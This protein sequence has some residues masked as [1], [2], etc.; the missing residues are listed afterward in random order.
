MIDKSDL[1]TLIETEE[2]RGKRRML[3]SVSGRSKWESY[4]LDWVIGEEHK[5]GDSFNNTHNL[6]PS[7]TE[8]HSWVTDNRSYYHKKWGGQKRL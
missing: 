7:R 6:N 1:R 3:V 4:N 2:R 5:N 8:Y